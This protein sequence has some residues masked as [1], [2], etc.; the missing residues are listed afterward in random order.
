MIAPRLTRVRDLS[1]VWYERLLSYHYDAALVKVTELLAETQ[2]DENGCMVT[3]T[4]EPRKVRFMSGQDR[5][6]RFVYCIQNQ[7]AT[8]RHQVVRH[9]CHNRRCMNP[10]HLTIGD[11]RDNLNDDRERRANGVDWHTL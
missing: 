3:V 2:T 11:R 1:Q 4:A 8:N 9:L 10:R 7:L 6:Y 5:A